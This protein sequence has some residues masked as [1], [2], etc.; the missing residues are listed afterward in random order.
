MDVHSRMVT[1]YYLSFDPPSETSV[2][3]CVAHSILPKQEWLLLHKVDADWP[4]WGVPK[5]IYVDNGAD[6]RS[7]N[8]QRSCEM[9]GI[10]L[11][12]RPVKRPNYGGHIERMLGT[13]LREIHALPGT[14][15]SA[16]KHREGYDS[17]KNAVMTTSEFE[18]WL[19]GLICKV[20]HQRVHS[21]IGMSPIRK[22]EIGIL[23]DGDTPGIG[24]PP[25]PAGNS[26]V[27]LDFLP[28]FSRT[29]Q[30]FGVTI[31]GV[32]YYAESLRHW[33]NETEPGS[34]KKREFIFRR[35]PRD[36]RLVWFYD[37]VLEEYFQIP[38][39]D[40]SIPSL[41]IWEYHQAKEKL[42][43]EGEKSAKPHQVLQSL[44]ELR[45]QVEESKGKTKKARRH[46]QRRKEHTKKITPTNPL[47]V[48]A[49]PLPVTEPVQV[50]GLFDGDV[51]PFGEIE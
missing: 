11:E 20:Y 45:E 33:I 21:S 5:K 47:Q 1:G 34:S 13:I 36:I 42:K 15:F 16:V 4:V 38:T 50:G 9:Y 39:A 46:A 24:V 27:L 35:D 40:Q 3:M 14:T 28:A 32:T 10:N 25:R 51:E 7:N 30:A 12:F 23:G 31:D 49:K 43:R 8:F 18:A 44:T 41:S 6:F 26:T 29:I 48:E 22:W 37:P 19:V 17:E 2:A